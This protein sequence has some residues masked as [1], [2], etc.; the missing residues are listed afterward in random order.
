MPV[1]MCLHVCMVVYAYPFA[2]AFVYV[3]GHHS[4][5]RARIDLSHAP[6]VRAPRYPWGVLAMCSQQFPAQLWLHGVRAY[7]LTTLSAFTPGIDVS[8][9]TQI[10]KS[11][12]EQIGQ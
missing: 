1:R 10:S 6:A 12:R 8:P 3:C 11:E 2:R 9:K 7:P 5:S 4:V